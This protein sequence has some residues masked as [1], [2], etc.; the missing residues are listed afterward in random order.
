[1]PGVGG[2]LS[3]STCGTSG[4]LAGVGKMLAGVWGDPPTCMGDPKARDTRR[5]EPIMPGG[6]CS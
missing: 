4:G 3:G 5:L 6:S 2:A 1:M